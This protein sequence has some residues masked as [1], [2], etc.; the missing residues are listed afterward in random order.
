M[1]QFK[2]Q[3]EARNLFDFSEIE[4]EMAA[5]P[6]MSKN[7]AKER[8]I[9][10]SSKQFQHGQATA[11]DVLRLVML[12]S[13]KYDEIDRDLLRLLDQKGCQEGAMVL[14]PLLEY[15]GR[16]KRSTEWNKLMEKRTAGRKF[17]SRMKNLLKDIPDV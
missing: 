6:D 8:I 9:S 12:W 17:M 2:M 11:R 5:D 1:K 3:V 4:Q 14:Q 15:A 10:L 7:E 13:L 16:D